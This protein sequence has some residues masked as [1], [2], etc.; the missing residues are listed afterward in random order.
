VDVRRPG[1]D[2]AKFRRLTEEWRKMAPYLL[3][4]FYPLTPY[5]LGEDVW[6]AWQFDRPDLGG[7]VVQAF[8]RSESRYET[9]RFPLRGLPPDARYT[10]IDLDGASPPETT[11]RELTERGL[12]V[13]IKDRPGSAILLYQ[14]AARGSP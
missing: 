6:I 8:R 2:W 12:L 7:G 14:R 4:D 10:L 13:G 1:V 3:G 11:G 9:A 5:S